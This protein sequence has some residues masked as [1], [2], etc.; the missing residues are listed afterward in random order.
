[1]LLSPFDFSRE[2]E[3]EEQHLG[4][5]EFPNEE[6][7]SKRFKIDIGYGIHLQEKTEGPEYGPRSGKEHHDA[8]DSIDTLSKIL[9]KNNETEKNNNNAHGEI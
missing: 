9:F 1:M 2:N 8:G 3:S 7:L 5:K 6:D 4:E